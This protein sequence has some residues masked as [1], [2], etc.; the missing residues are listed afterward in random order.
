[1]T[2]TPFAR[3]LVGYV[4]TEQGTD[5]RALCVDLAAACSA[6][7]LLVSVVAAVWRSTWG[8]CN[9][10]SSREGLGIAAQPLPE[11]REGHPGAVSAEPIAGLRLAAVHVLARDADE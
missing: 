11:R 6:D 3:I 1:M 4:P 2:P 9:A 8:L 10:L 7:L 5:A